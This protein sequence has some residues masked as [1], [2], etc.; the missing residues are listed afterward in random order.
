MSANCT[1]RWPR[2]R[3]VTL[4]LTPSARVPMIEGNRSLI[5]QALANLV[6]NA[7]KYTP[8]GGT[9]TRPHRAWPPMAWIFRVAD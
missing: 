2:R 8:P 5:S 9:V 4:T 6:D 3:N 7:I 1:S